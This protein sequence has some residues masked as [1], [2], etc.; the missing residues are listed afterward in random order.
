MLNKTS[1][2]LA[3]A[4]RKPISL[5]SLWRNVDISDSFCIIF[6]LV[7]FCLHS[8]GIKDLAMCYLFY[9][10]HKQEFSYKLNDK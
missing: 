4:F 5:W 2:R 6:F 3:S 10:R 8:L 9:A 1:R 7:P